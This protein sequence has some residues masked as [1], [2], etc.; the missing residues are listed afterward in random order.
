MRNLIYLGVELSMKPIMIDGEE[1][2]LQ[3]WDT[4]GQEKYRTVTKSFYKQA[5]GAV[6]VFDLT[7]KESFD[8]LEEWWKLLEENA[9]LD[10]SI[11]VVGNKAD[12]IKERKVENIEINELME[13]KQ[14]KYYETSAKSK[15]NIDN[16][17]LELAKCIKKKKFDN[18][19]EDKN[20]DERKSV[21]INSSWEAQ[22]PVMRLKPSYK[23]ENCC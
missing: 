4:A 5:L 6:L 10:V 8:G 11:I 13:R 3:I 9:P 20:I 22:S 16:V 15:K 19:V 17:F 1:I 14:L 12:L 23:K 21:R 18:I 7:S 2:K